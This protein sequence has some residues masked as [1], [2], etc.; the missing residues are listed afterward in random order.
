MPKVRLP[1]Q[2]ETKAQADHLLEV[3]QD[4]CFQEVVDAVKAGADYKAAFNAMRQV[5]RAQGAVAVIPEDEP[6]DPEGV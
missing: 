1:K 2:I 5:M 3:V 4:W 6:E